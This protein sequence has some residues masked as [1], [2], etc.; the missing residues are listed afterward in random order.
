M[1]NGEEVQTQFS[2]CRTTLNTGSRRDESREVQRKSLG[3]RFSWRK[4]F[5]LIHPVRALETSFLFIFWRKLCSLSLPGSE[6]D[7]GSWSRKFSVRMP[8]A[9]TFFYAR[10]S[11]ECLRCVCSFCIF[12]FRFSAKLFR[13]TLTWWTKIAARKSSYVAMSSSIPKK[14]FCA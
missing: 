14:V 9:I 6:D 13:H 4:C 5:H 10:D 7:V 1:W 8:F 11:A 2:F 3:D 12:Q